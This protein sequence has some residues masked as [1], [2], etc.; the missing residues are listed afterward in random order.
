M[1]INYRGGKADAVIE[2]GEGRAAGDIFPLGPRR[3]TWSPKTGQ[4]SG[5]RQAQAGGTVRQMAQSGPVG[6]YVKWRKPPRP[7][8][9]VRQMARTARPSQYLIPFTKAKPIMT[10]LSNE[11][12]I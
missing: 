2:E 11:R 3:S 12:P 10:K 6:Q 4:G 8:G 9:T 1:L 5:H 7:S